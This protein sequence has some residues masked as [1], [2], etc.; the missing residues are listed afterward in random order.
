MKSITPVISV[1]ILIM[2]TIAAAGAAYFFIFLSMEEL[3]SQS[4][5]E[6]HPGMDG[7]RL[8]LVSVT[9]SKA[10]IRN[11]G[12]NSISEVLVF[13]NGELLEYTLSEPILPG[14]FLEIPY[15]SRKLGE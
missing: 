12:L 11:D 15:N 14:E 9:G 5:A 2:L 13:V 1:I 8:S 4:G 3:Q 7:T 10:I 6:T